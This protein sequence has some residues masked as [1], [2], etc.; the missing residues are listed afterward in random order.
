MSVD[1]YI[2]GPKGEMDWIVWNWDDKL[3]K[4]VFELTEPVDTVLILV[5]PWTCK[6]YGI[7]EHLSI[8]DVF[9]LVDVFGE[10]LVPIKHNLVIF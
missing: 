7:H 6:T 9:C 4:Y 2:A 3:E 5:L 10:Y 1:G 8:H